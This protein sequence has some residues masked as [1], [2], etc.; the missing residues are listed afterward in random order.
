MSLDLKKYVDKGVI[1]DLFCRGALHQW[2]KLKNVKWNIFTRS[3]KVKN[4]SKRPYHEHELTLRIPGAA[5]TPGARLKKRCVQRWHNRPRG[6]PTQPLAV[7][8][9]RAPARLRAASR[10][11]KF[12]CVG[13]RT[14]H[15]DQLESKNIFVLRG[16]LSFREDYSRSAFP[17]KRKKSHKSE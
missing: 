9:P 4:R 17:E 15:L 1:G 13:C 16:I 2:C 11:T 8:R 6:R 12:V 3:P 5:T 14:K 7:N 10:N